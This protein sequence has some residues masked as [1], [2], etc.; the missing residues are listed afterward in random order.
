[1]AV[2]AG[3]AASRNRLFSLRDFLSVISAALDA[4]TEGAI[5]AEAEV[6]GAGLALGL[7]VGAGRTFAVSFGEGAVVGS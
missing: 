1:M 7:R 3:T 4:L 5:E 6:F 2:S